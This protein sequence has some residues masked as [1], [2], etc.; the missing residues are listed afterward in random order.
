MVGVHKNKMS[1][2]RVTH[3]TVKLLPGR[4]CPALESLLQVLTIP[5]PHPDSCHCTP[6]ETTDNG[7]KIL[8]RIPVI[9]VRKHLVSELTELFLCLLIK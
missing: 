4:P 6:S 5:L 2:F 7:S 9:H 3:A 8:T 1:A